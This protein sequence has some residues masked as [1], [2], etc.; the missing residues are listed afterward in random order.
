MDAE[1]RFLELYDRT[2]DAV[3]RHAYFRVSDR[4]LALDITQEAFA[5]MWECVCRGDRIDNHKAFLFRITGNLVIDHYRRKKGL[6]L[7]QLAEDG[8]D[9]EGDDA[10]TIEDAAAGKEALAL[11]NRL[12]PRDR[13]VL[14]LRYVEGLSVAE[15]AEA[16]GESGN[17][18]SVRIHRATKRLKELHTHG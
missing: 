8:F 5:R 12:P 7:D 2:A 10:G 1:R 16:T 15:I 14:T 4:E 6:S 9:P 13:A 3:F 11:L 17:A 18:V